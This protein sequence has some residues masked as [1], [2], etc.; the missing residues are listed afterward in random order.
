MSAPDAPLL[1]ARAVTTRRSSRARCG[2]WPASC[3]RGDHASARR[4]SRA[5]HPER[6]R[7]RLI[8]RALTDA[9]QAEKYVSF[10]RTSRRESSR[11]RA[12]RTLRTERSLKSA[13]RHARSGS[14]LG[15]IGDS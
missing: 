12:G 5:P 7:E 11:C 8:K 1:G 13:G 3:A 4:G 14:H 9:I 10:G 2:A 15:L 6:R